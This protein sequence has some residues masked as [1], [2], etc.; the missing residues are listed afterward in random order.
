MATRDASRLVVSH[1]KDDL[2]LVPCR[3]REDR[4]HAAHAEARGVHGGWEDEV[5]DCRAQ[6]PRCVRRIWMCD[7]P[8]C[9]HTY[10]L[11][12]AEQCAHGEVQLNRFLPAL[13]S[14]CRRCRHLH[15]EKPLRG[16]HT[17][18]AAGRRTRAEG[19]TLEVD[20]LREPLAAAGWV[21]D[22]AATHLLD[23]G[24]LCAKGGEVLDIVDVELTLVGTG[25]HNMVFIQKLERGLLCSG[26]LEARIDDQTMQLPRE[27]ETCDP[28]TRTHERRTSSPMQRCTILDLRRQRHGYRR[29]GE[30]LGGTSNHREET[31][32]PRGLPPDVILPSK[33]FSHEDC[34][35]W[36]RKNGS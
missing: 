7:L 33:D 34:Y 20:A 26:Q 2:A 11:D 23:C 9:G 19:V 4:A 1:T 27:T 36:E 8:D 31:L 32:C 3:S 6:D 17:E 35:L 21:C 25:E 15:D 12:A 24:R 5:W 16:V 28:R 29:H 10:R 18:W 13:S 14:L 30:C 22:L